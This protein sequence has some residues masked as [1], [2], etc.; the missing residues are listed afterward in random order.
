LRVTT[1][2]RA[3]VRFDRTMTLQFSFLEH[4]AE[5]AAGRVRGAGDERG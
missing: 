1:N 5:G 4:V 2:P 3:Q